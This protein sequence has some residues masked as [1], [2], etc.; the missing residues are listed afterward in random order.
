MAGL[1]SIWDTAQTSKLKQGKNS[2]DIKNSLPLFMMETLAPVR[3][4]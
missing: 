1:E 4:V 2:V 3:F